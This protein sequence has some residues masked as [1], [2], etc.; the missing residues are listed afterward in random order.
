LLCRGDVHVTAGW[1]GGDMEENVGLLGEVDK[2]VRAL[3]QRH[4]RLC[5]VEVVRESLRKWRPNYGHAAAGK[6]ESRCR[7]SSHGDYHH[8]SKDVL[9]L[10][11]PLRRV[12]PAR[13][14][15][16]TIRVVACADAKTAS[17][18]ARV[19]NR[20]RCLA[21]LTTRSPR[22]RPSRTRTSFARMSLLPTS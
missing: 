16:G 8:W 20:C 14:P 17:P 2:R 19:R 18:I 12:G 13:S 7:H 5:A 22:R 15:G 10:K 11:P 4:D 21:K 1:E 3:V 9:Q 6:D